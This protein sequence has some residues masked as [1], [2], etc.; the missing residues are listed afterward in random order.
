MLSFK[1]S[2]DPYYG[3]ATGNGQDNSGQNKESKAKKGDPS[4]EETMDAFTKTQKKF[5]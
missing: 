3:T 1:S 2:N 5:D 4:R